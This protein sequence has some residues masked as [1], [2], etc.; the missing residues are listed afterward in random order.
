MFQAG[1]R[2]YKAT[3]SYL[4]ANEGTNDDSF[5]PLLPPLNEPLPTD[6]GWVTLTGEFICVYSSLVPFIGSEL[7]FAPQAK[8]D[9]GVTWLMIMKGTQFSTC[10]SFRF[11]YN[12]FSQF[13]SPSIETASDSVSAWIRRW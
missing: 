13:Y 5:V 3:I 4:P 12:P 2:T 10:I 9:D 7:C 11:S 6:Q 1:L 8:L